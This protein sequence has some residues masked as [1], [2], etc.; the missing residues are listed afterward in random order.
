MC[1]KYVETICMC[2]NMCEI[3]INNSS[4]F[5]LIYSEHFET[6][7]TAHVMNHYRYLVSITTVATVMDAPEYPLRPIHNGSKSDIDEGSEPLKK[8]FSVV[9]YRKNIGTTKPRLVPNNSI[10]PL[11]TLSIP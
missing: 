5:F 10:K 1:V 2:M 11:S 9:V 3:C 4:R 7:V 6:S 8:A